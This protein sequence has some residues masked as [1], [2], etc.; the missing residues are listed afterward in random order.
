VHRRRGEEAGV[1]YAEAYL[2]ADSTKERPKLPATFL[3]PKK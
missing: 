3:S 2:R 1:K